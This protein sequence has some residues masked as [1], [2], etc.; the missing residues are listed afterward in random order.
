[1]RKS[2]LL[3]HLPGLLFYL[4]HQDTPVTLVFGYQDT[5][6]SER[7]Q[8]VLG[9]RLQLYSPSPVGGTVLMAGLLQVDG[10]EKTTLKPLFGGLLASLKGEIAAANQD[11][12][13]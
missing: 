12:A 2:L 3:L 9:R 8:R 10:P 1:M 13:V 7:F 5:E 4:S 11:V 6:T